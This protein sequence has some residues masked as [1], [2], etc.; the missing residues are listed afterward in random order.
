M[1]RQV[2]TITDLQ[3]GTSWETDAQSIIN[4]INYSRFLYN[5]IIL[6]SSAVLAFHP[7]NKITLFVLLY[8]LSL[9][10]N[11]KFYSRNH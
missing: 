1:I 8:K 9:D 6:L 3:S 5:A 11:V 10:R 7:I 2:F 4:I